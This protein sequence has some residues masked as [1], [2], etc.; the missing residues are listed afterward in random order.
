MF[1]DELDKF[2][3][4]IDLRNIIFNT[5]FSYVKINLTWG[6]ADVAE[7][8]VCHF[9]R[10]VNDATHDGDG[11]ADEVICFGS[12]GLGGFFEVEEGAAAGW[13]SDEFCFGY[14]MLGGL[15]DGIA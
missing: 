15:E 3:D 11:D 10:A 6:A 2:I 13:T 8:G 5:F 9:A 12:D 4:G 1:F 7:I 14:T